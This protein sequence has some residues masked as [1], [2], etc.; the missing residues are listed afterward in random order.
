LDIIDINTTFGAY[1]GKLMYPGE[2]GLLAALGENGVARALTL[3]TSGIFYNDMAGNLDTMR[4]CLKHD[5]KMIPVATINPTSHRSLQ[6]TQDLALQPFAFFRFFPGLQ[7][8]PTDFAPFVQVV[9]MLGD[10]G[11]PLLE[12]SIKL[13][14]PSR[15]WKIWADGGEALMV[16]VE[17]PGDV[18]MLAR[19][20]AD[21]PG[22]VII[23][24]VSAA[25]LTETLSVMQNF[26][27]LHIET[28]M[29]HIPDAL[30][31]LRDTVGIHRVL[32]GSGAPGLSLPAALAYVQG[33]SLSESDKR[34]VLFENASSLLDG[35]L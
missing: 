1:P 20:V 18:T 23:E 15:G 14:T 34:A 21:Y 3:A 31:I 29:L 19:V 35:T 22:R 11:K 12:R 26:E 25:T 10:A 7:G 5:D 9:R 27:H 8:W 30:A 28:H 2:D 24:G 16:S 4:T 17:K 33:S 32:F 13:P 6:I